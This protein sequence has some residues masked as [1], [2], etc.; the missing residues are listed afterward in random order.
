ML[1]HADTATTM[2]YLGLTVDDLAKVQEKRD[3]YMGM[4]RMRM[5][6]NPQTHQEVGR[7]VLFAR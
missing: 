7:S 3:D 2:S 6:A 4:I 5:K 1:G